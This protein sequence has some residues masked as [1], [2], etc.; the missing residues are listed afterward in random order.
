METDGGVFLMKILCW[1]MLN[2]I[3]SVEW[4]LTNTLSIASHTKMDSKINY[5]WLFVLRFS[6]IKTD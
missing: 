1:C 2:G 4:L 6:S 5:D 3:G